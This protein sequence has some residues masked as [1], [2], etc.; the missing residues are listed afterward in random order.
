L[1]VHELCVAAMLLGGVVAGFRAWQM[2]EWVGTRLRSVVRPSAPIELARH[3]AAGWLAVLGALLG[4]LTA[5]AV[6]V[7]M[8]TRA[9]LA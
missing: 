1:R 3:R 8:Y 4:V 6:L 2:R 7:G 5:G 9:G